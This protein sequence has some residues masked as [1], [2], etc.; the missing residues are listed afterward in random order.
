MAVIVSSLPEHSNNVAYKTEKIAK[1][2]CKPPI[3]T[4]QVPS[5]VMMLEEE[6]MFELSYSPASAGWN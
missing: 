1:S 4:A 3:L 2:L 5:C 6:C